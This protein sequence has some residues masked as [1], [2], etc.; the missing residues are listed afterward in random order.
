[1][2]PT[3]RTFQVVAPDGT[4]FRRSHLRNVYRH[5]VLSQRG[6]TTAWRL[7]LWTASTEKAKSYRQFVLNRGHGV[8]KDVRILDAVDVTG[9]KVR[10]G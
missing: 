4:V 1:V 3:R 7:L 6:P 2:T 5:A 9:Q 8:D 10:R